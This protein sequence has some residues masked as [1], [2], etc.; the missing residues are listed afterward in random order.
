MEAA[1]CLVRL[2]R[3]SFSAIARKVTQQLRPS[4]RPVTSSDV[5]PAPVIC[6]QGGALA[7][8]RLSV[9]LIIRTATLR[10]V[11]RLAIRGLQ[12]YPRGPSAAPQRGVHT[13]SHAPGR[14]T[15]PLAVAEMMD[16]V[17]LPGALFGRFR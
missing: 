16:R 9:K 5:V 1:T 13:Q 8:Q 4:I 14:V 3:L 6:T 2:L 10:E 15:G 17:R 7:R 11:G 12:W